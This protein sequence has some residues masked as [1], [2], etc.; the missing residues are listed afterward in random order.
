MGY[1]RCG[2][3]AQRRKGLDHHNATLRGGSPDPPRT[4]LNLPARRILF[5]VGQET[6]RARGYGALRDYFGIGIF[7]GPFAGSF[8]GSFVGLGL[9]PSGTRVNWPTRDST[10]RPSLSVVITV[11]GMKLPPG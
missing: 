5:A 3:G 10:I 7:A 9:A 2:T 11:M 8:A 1:P 4:C 6:H